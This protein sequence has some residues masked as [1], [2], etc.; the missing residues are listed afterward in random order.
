MSRS[1]TELQI[2][3]HE[4]ARRLGWW[5]DSNTKTVGDQIALMHSEL[6]EALEVIRHGHSP[7]EFWGLPA[8]HDP[9]RKPE[10]FGI[11]LA[12]CVI[13]ILD[14]CQRYGIGLEQ[15]IEIK[16]AYNETRPYRHGGKKL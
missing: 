9:G 4:W 15:C 2:Y 16:M 5:D 13:R 12:D 11:E 7:E 14:T 10:G 3:I 6:S 1:M 8:T